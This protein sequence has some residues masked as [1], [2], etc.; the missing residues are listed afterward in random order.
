MQSRYWNNVN[1]E[2]K[3]GINK[4]YNQQKMEDCRRDRRRETKINGELSTQERLS[5]NFPSDNY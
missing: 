3:T 4:E 5:S 2:T 1:R